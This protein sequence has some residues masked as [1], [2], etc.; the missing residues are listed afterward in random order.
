MD[1]VL[2]HVVD[3]KGYSI[4]IHFGESWIGG[5]V[6]VGEERE[7]MDGMGWSWVVLLE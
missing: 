2:S 3:S 4:A 7:R 5:Y 6:K 1:V